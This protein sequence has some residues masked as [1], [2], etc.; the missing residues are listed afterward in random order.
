MELLPENLLHKIHKYRHEMLY[1]KVMKQLKTYSLD[2]VS[3]VSLEFL[4]YGCYEFGEFGGIRTPCIHI[5]N[6]NATPYE[7]LCLIH[8]EHD[9]LSDHWCRP[10]GDVL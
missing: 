5:I 4:E 7:I 1:S 6:I 9:I 8:N 2:T 10:Y 3:I